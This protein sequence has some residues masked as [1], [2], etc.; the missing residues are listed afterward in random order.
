MRA[1]ICSTCY[2]PTGPDDDNLATL[3]PL[4]GISLG[5]AARQ[6]RTRRPEPALWYVTL[7]VS[8]DRLRPEEVR[9]ALERLS[10][11]QPFLVS[12]GYASTRAEI[13]YWDESVDVEGAVA[14]ACGCGP[15]T[16]A[17]RS[18]R[19]GASSA[20]RSSTATPPAAA[21]RRRRPRSRCGARGDPR[22]G[23]ADCADRREAAP[24]AREA[25][26]ADH[27]HRG[28]RR[29]RLTRSR[30]AT[31]MSARPC[32]PSAVRA[33]EAARELATASGAAK[34]AA[35]L[36]V[37]DALESPATDR[38]VAANAEDLHRGRARGPRRGPA[39]PAA[40]GPAAGRARSPTPSA[41]SPRCPTRS[42]R[43]SAARPCRTGCGCARSGCRWASSG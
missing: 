23:R 3:T 5:D 33:R 12:A 17:P 29:R 22:A 8:G 13:R 25:T 40:P 20:S 4:R 35:L 18:C 26:A 14:Q 24:A 7:T 41:T 30:G 28:R 15:S 11:E 32:T 39:R 34:T 37:A 21:G 31:T 19:R 6:G 2:V 9:E 16:S 42:A 43:S 10:V 1:R 36:A 38:I 27:E